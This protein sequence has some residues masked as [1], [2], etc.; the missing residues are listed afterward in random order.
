MVKKMAL[1]AA[2]L[3]ALLAVGIPVS[4]ESPEQYAPEAAYTQ[5]IAPR[6]TYIKRFFGKCSYNNNS[7]SLSATILPYD[8]KNQTSLSVTLQRQEGSQWKNVKT[9]SA[10]GSGTR[11]TVFSKEY[12]VKD[13]SY[14]IK[15]TGKVLDGTKVL[16]TTTIYD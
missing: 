16:E 15:V 5:E 7:V 10:K 12:A 3:S 4:A 6:Y 1:T 9:W 11:G 2:C 14:R 8:A 13:G